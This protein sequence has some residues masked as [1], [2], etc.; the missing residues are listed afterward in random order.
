LS[1]LAGFPQQR[2]PGTGQTES[3]QTESGQTE[4][5]KPAAT[6]SGR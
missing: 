6:F 4:S 3:G 2:P 5:G 1:A